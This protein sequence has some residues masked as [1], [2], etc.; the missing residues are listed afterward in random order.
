MM[1]RGH[2]CLQRPDSSGRFLD[3]ADPVPSLLEAHS[4]D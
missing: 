3:G 1:W 2:S 4:H